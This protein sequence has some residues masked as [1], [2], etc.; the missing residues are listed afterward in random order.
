LIK[1]LAEE[2]EIEFPPSNVLVL[3]TS[4]MGVTG[5]PYIG[6]YLSRHS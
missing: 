3:K 2:V 6:S 1:A 5:E 4:K